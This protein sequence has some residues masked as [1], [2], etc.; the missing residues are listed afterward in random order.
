M[1]LFLK[2]LSF[3]HLLKAALVL[4]QKCTLSLLPSPWKVINGSKPPSRRSC[5][6]VQNVL[7]RKLTPSHTNLAIVHGVRMWD[8]Y[9]MHNDMR[10]ENMWTGSQ[11]QERVGALPA[12]HGAQK[13]SKIQ[14]YSGLRCLGA[15]TAAP[16]PFSNTA[17]ESTVAPAAPSLDSIIM[18]ANPKRSW[19]QSPCLGSQTLNGLSNLKAE[20]PAPF[21]EAQY[22]PHAFKHANG[23][24]PQY[25]LLLL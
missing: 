16:Q 18:S 5:W 3:N 21:M 24:S 1:F 14:Q 10:P 9:F 20:W 17:W 15:S 2:L 22:I 12:L 8:H 6:K 11:T 13:W 4:L 25:I 7:I 23:N 19:R